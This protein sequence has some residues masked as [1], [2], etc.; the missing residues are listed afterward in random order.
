L[1]RNPRKKAKMILIF[2][3]PRLPL[4]RKPKPKRPQ[5]RRRKLRSK[6]GN[7]KQKIVKKRKNVAEPKKRKEDLRQHVVLF[8]TMEMI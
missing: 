8:L 1:P 2:S 6:G 4:L 7:K 5:R 3:M